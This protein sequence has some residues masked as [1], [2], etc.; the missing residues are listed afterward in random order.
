M[1]SSIKRRQPSSSADS[2]VVRE[3]K[4]VPDLATH[5][6][7]Q[8]NEALT[9]RGIGLLFADLI[10]YNKYA[11]Y[12]S[13]L[14]NRMN[15]DPPSGYSRCSVSQIVAADKAVWQ[16]LI[17]EGVRPK[18]S[19]TGELPLGDAMLDAL[20]SYE[21][22]FVLLPLQSKKEDPKD[23]KA[24]KETREQSDKV[25]KPPKK[26]NGKG[27]SKGKTPQGILKLGGVSKTPEGENLCFAYNRIEM[28]TWISFVRQVLWKSPN[29]PA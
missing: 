14:C 15:R 8:V 13:T 7:T 21:V 26:G 9:R 25:W 23:K 28:S 6:A 11:R 18:R 19:S 16:K 24:K 20:K 22:S 29:R 10:E 5:S 2:L 3:A 1:K 4:E 17:E 12:L 27:K